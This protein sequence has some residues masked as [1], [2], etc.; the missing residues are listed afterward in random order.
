[1][2]DGI[3]RGRYALRQGRVYE[4]TLARPGPFKKPRRKAPERDFHWAVAKYLNAAL[5]EGYWWTSIPA[6]GGGFHRGV[7]WNKRGYKAGTP[8]LVVFRP[9]PYHEDGDLGD[10]LWLELKAATGS[11]SQVQKDVHAHLKA[12]GHR[13]AV[14]KTLDEV[15]AELAE[16]CF[17]EKLKAEIITKGSGCVFCDINARHPK[18]IKCSL[19]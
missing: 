2:G 14:V 9:N 15:E 11:L 18:G 5:P 12:L 19:S 17:P 10:T 4:Q 13:V 1:M 3:R 6:G 7:D 16:F 8:D